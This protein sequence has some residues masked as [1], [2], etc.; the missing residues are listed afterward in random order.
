M[1]RK[2][3]N[4]YTVQ[5]FNEI[6]FAS[7]PSITGSDLI[8]MMSACPA[9][10]T[11][12]GFLGIL[13]FPEPSV[14]YACAGQ[15]DVQSDNPEDTWIGDRHETEKKAW[16]GWLLRRCHDWRRQK[17]HRR[18]TTP[19]ERSSSH[20]LPRICVGR[21]PST[22]HG[23]LLRW[24]PTGEWRTNIRLHLIYNYRFQRFHVDSLG[25]QPE[26]FVYFVLYSQYP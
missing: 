21:E 26:M 20:A 10:Y 2:H 4:T 22:D 8:A 25:I 5:I 12:V 24:L 16:D 13:G 19:S 3:E 11:A 1:K 7:R 15:F 18:M 9:H 17:C 6:K 23:V 14:W